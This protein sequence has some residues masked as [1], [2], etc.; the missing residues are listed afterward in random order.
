MAP[1]SRD[2]GKE[3]LVFE[4]RITK[5]FNI[6]YPIICG[7]MFWLGRAEL[8]AAIANAGGLCFMTA[9]TFDDPE[10]VRAEIRKARDLTDKPI[11]LNI[12]LFPAVRPQ[13]VEAWVEVAVEEKIPVVETSGRSPE[14]IVGPLHEGG[15]KIMHKVPG[16]RYARTVERLGCDSVC[17]VGYECGGHPGMD[18]ITTLVLVPLTVDAVKIPVVAG[19]G[20]ADG[21]GLAAALALG[22]DA[23]LMGTRFMATQECRGHPAWKEYLVNATE[24]DT[25]YIMR[26]IGNPSRVAKNALTDKVMEMEARGTTLNELL[27]VIKARLN[28]AFDEGK[29]E[30]DFVSMGQCVGLIHDVPTVKDLIERIMEEALEARERLIKAVPQAV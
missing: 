15:V 26:S 20:F 16:V 30:D 17:I 25:A 12:N 22:A 18:Q 6:K 10:K 4:T 7:G 14:A 27:S 29:V 9:A 11:G 21:R 24:G 3:G 28:A 1:V 5:L 13:P 2:E 19:G 8:A 23:V